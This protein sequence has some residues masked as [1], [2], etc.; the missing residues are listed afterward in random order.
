MQ[1]QYWTVTTAR[2]TQSQCVRIKQPKRRSWHVQSGIFVVSETAEGYLGNSKSEHN[3]KQRNAQYL[4]VGNQS[5]SSLLHLL[6][7]VFLLRS[8]KR[9]TRR[10]KASPF[11]FLLR[12]FFSRQMPRGAATSLFALSNS[13]SPPHSSPTMH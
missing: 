12:V 3:K 13:N 2:V 11:R 1:G 7:L 10:P 4:I 6:V 5:L 9:L 8:P